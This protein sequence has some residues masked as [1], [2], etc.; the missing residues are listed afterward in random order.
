MDRSLV[1]SEPACLRTSNDW[2]IFEKETQAREAVRL[3][4]IGRTISGE[5]NR[6]FSWEP[7]GSRLVYAANTTSGAELFVMTL[8]NGQPQ[9]LTDAL[10]SNVNP[11]WSPDGSK[12][13]FASHRFGDWEIYVM[14]ADGSNPVRISRHSASDM[15]PSWS[16]FLK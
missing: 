1:S 4:G 12:I 5:P 9:Q 15:S 10:G 14:D 6:W 11:S 13:A 7:G 3:A 16:P 2:A 8:P